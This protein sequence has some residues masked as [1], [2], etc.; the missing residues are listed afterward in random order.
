MD[1]LEE[2]VRRIVNSVNIVNVGTRP[3]QPGV[4]SLSQY[5]CPTENYG[6]RLI[7]GRVEIDK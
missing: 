3:Q 1:N 5:F 4:G 7:M 6:V 2:L